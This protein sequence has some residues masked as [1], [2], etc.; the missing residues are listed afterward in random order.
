VA[1]LNKKDILYFLVGR[2]QGTE[3]RLGWL[4][5]R[6]ERGCRALQE[7]RKKK[8]AGTE[9]ETEQSVRE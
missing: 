8:T 5:K 3:T 2:D 6:R 4:E 7:A 9:T 1:Y